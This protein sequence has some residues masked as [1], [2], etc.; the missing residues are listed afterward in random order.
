[1]AMLYSDIKVKVEI[2]VNQFLCRVDIAYICLDE[3]ILM[4]RNPNREILYT[5]EMLEILAEEIAR[6]N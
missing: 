2:Q 1:M 3:L 4:A 6:R 5:P